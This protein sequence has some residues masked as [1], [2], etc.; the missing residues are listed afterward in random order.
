VNE[1]A[2]RFGGIGREAGGIGGGAPDVEDG[3]AGG[4]LAS[5][6]EGAEGAAAGLYARIDVR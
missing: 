6:S 2:V 5:A 3:E 1:A 4:P